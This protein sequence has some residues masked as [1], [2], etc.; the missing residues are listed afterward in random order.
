MPP[1]CAGGHDIKNLPP[2]LQ[3]LIGKTKNKARDVAEF[4]NN[5]L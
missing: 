1:G 2:T 3:V 4:I 5:V